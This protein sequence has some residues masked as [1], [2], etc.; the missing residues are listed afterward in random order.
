MD[1]I[2]AARAVYRLTPIKTLRQAT[3]RQQ[4]NAVKELT[5]LATYTALQIQSAKTLLQ[6]ASI[7]EA[8]TQYVQ[9]IVFDKSGLCHHFDL[10][11][12][13]EAYLKDPRAA[14]Q[15]SNYQR[16]QNIT[17]QTNLTEIN[18]RD[19]AADTST[20][21]T[22]LAIRKKHAPYRE[23]AIRAFDPKV[24]ERVNENWSLSSKQLV[25]YDFLKTNPLEDLFRTLTAQLKYLRLQPGSTEVVKESQLLLAYIQHR[26]MAFEPRLVSYRSMATRGS[27]YSHRWSPLFAPTKDVGSSGK[28]YT[29]PEL[30]KI[31]EGIPVIQKDL[32]KK[33]EAVIHRSITF[34]LVP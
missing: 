15:A 26:D 18:P 1:T 5:P 28:Q 29:V 8:N 30:Q 25:D 31:H 4:Q 23:A 3:Y 17:P 13:L 11:V 21:L 24:V 34:S 33:M 6:V 10:Y 14:R 2:N 19:D 12:E 22:S 20:S 16:C 32:E 27:R 7:E 9:F